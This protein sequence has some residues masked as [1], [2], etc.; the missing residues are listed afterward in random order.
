VYRSFFSFSIRSKR[1]ECSV[2]GRLL[3]VTAVEM[4]LLYR[5]IV[6]LQEEMSNADGTRK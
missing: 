1:R 3:L 2:P 6:A 5:K 4:R